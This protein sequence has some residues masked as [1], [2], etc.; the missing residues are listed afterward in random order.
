[1][2]EMQETRDTGSISEWER[3][4]GEGNGNPLQYSCLDNHMDREAWWSIVHGVKKG[5]KRL[6]GC[7]CTHEHMHIH[8]NKTSPTSVLVLSRVLLKYKSMSCKN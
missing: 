1:M 7:I 6:S 2:Q 3:S 4:P 8:V 5:Q